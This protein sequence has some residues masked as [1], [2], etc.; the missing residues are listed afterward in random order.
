MF[1]LVINNFFGLKFQAR[2]LFLI[3]FCLNGLVSCA[4]LKPAKVE[5]TF[6]DPQTMKP[7]PEMKVR[8][9]E[10]GYSRDK[11]WYV[12]DSETRHERTDENGKVIF[13]GL[14]MT[15]WGMTAYHDGNELKYQ[16]SFND[17]GIIYVEQSE[18]LSWDDRLEIP[19]RV[20]RDQPPKL[21]LDI[22]LLH[23]DKDELS[24][25][26]WSGCGGGNSE[27]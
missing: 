8:M 21:L 27:K 12:G 18:V 1:N 7:V 26:Y 17:N 20:K 6:L 11:L 25:L 19:L 3:L 15:G 5:L 13:G 16:I 10:N 2:W 14:E 9:E 4:S 22:N 23:K 24:I